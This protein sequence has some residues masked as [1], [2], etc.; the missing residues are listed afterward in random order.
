MYGSERC[1]NRVFRL[2]QVSKICWNSLQTCCIS[3]NVTPT[4]IFLKEKAVFEDRINF[5]W[6]W[7]DLPSAWFTLESNGVTFKIPKITEPLRISHIK[8]ITGGIQSQIQPNESQG[9][10]FLQI[11]MFTVS[12]YFISKSIFSNLNFFSCRLRGTYLRFVPR[13]NISVFYKHIF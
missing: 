13:P 6:P 2:V 4:D 1:W 5:T 3:V 9:F 10:A 11:A 7:K 8:M 12:S